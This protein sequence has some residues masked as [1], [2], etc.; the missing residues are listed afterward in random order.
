MNNQATLHRMHELSL[1][2][3]AQA[4]EVFLQLPIHQHPTADLMLAELVETEHLH[5]WQRKTEL[6]IKN[7]RFRYRAS[8]EEVDYLP[9]RNLDKNLMLRLADMSF[10]SRHENVLIVGATGSGKSFLATALGY[11]ACQKGY[12][13]GYFALPKLLQKLHLA[14]ADGSYAKEL[15]R[16]ERLSLL[17]LDD[18]GLPV[19]DLSAR[20]ALLQMMEDRHGKGSVIITSQLP[21]A[22]WYEYL[23]DPTLADAILDRILHQAHRIELK[24]G[25]MRKRKNLSDINS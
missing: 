18:W 12:K 7:A 10:I 15:A 17:I 6:S 2:G 16:I 14:T 19:L 24:G 23:A 3:M 21:V 11:Q 9:E 8:I 4:F 5:R 22:K 1:T 20:M 25:S 13:V